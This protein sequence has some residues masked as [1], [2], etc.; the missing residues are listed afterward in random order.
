MWNIYQIK[1]IPLRLHYGILGCRA[2]KTC[3]VIWIK[4]WGGGV[5]SSLYLLSVW[6]DITCMM[7]VAICESTSFCPLIISDSL[8][9]GMYRGRAYCRYSKFET[10]NWPITDTWVSSLGH[11][12]KVIFLSYSKHYN[13]ILLKRI[14][15]K[16]D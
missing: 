7:C 2:K 4:G 16:L 12:G 13:W 5:V 6:K 14:D 3:I 11:I 15:I 9:I 8:G 1:Y 10:L